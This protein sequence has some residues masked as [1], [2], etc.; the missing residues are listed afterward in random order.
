MGGRVPVNE[1]TASTTM[2]GVNMPPAVVSAVATNI[3]ETPSTEIAIHRT[4]LCLRL[5]LH[6]PMHRIAPVQ[7]FR[8]EVRAVF[9]EYLLVRFVRLAVGGVGYDDVVVIGELA[10]RFGIRQ[11]LFGELVLGGDEKFASGT[12]ME[13][14]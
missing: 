11:R 4:D 12:F 6:H 5:S 9:V 1:S 14:R 13:N 8:F 7:N 10:V 2:C 3:L